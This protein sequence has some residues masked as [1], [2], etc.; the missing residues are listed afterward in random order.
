M[1]FFVN[2]FVF[3]K[4]KLFITLSVPVHN[5]FSLSITMNRIGDVEANALMW[6]VI[7]KYSCILVEC[8]N[9]I[10]ATLMLLICGERVNVY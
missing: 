2:I 4:I 5:F 6:H 7:F 10:I 1:T 8:N 9:I 3:V